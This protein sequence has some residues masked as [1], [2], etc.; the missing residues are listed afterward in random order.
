VITLPLLEIFT[1]FSGMPGASF[2]FHFSAV[3][4]Q[5]DLS[6]DHLQLKQ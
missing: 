4:Q 5:G 6:I 3:E 2:A 1:F